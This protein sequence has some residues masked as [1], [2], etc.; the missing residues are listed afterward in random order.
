MLHKGTTGN[1]LHMPNTML[2][3]EGNQ[4][5]DQLSNLDH[6]VANATSSQCEAQLCFFEDDEAAIKMIMKGSS[7]TMRHV[8]RTHRVALDWLFDRVNVDPTLQIKYVDTKNQLADMLTKSN[9]TRDEWNLLL[10]LLNIM[11]FSMFSCSHSLS[12]NKPNTMWKRTQER[13]TGEELA[14]SKPWPR[15]LISRNLLNV[16]QA[17]SSDSDASNIAVNPQLDSNSLQGSTWKHVQGR[18]QNPSN[19]F[20]RVASRQSVSREHMGKMCRVMCV[21]V[22]GAPGSSTRY[23]KSS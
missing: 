4:N 5:V 3:K 2:K 16:R 7:P 22:Q 23:R 12:I 21:S 20:S 11:N 1:S 8:S 18:D 9:F 17:S 13:K 15:C 6:V 10:R 19:E 14:V